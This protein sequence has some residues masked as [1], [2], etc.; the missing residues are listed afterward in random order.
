MARDHLY[1]IINLCHLN[2]STGGA[3]P[4]LVDLYS[5]DFAVR[6]EH[7]FARVDGAVR[8]QASCQQGCAGVSAVVD[9][10]ESAIPRG[11]PNKKPLP[12]PNDQF[13][14]YMVLNSYSER[15]CRML[16]HIRVNFS[17]GP[18]AISSLFGNSELWL[19]CD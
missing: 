3:V 12:P 15:G 17:E 1:R 18:S 19:T 13:S 4:Y 10:L 9:H 2:V 8:G 7:G 11:P 6:L 16:L 14:C 5:L